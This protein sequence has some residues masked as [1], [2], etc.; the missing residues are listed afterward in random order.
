MKETEASDWA[1]GLVLDSEKE[2]RGEARPMLIFFPLTIP[3]WALGFLT[4]Q[5]EMKRSC[6]PSHR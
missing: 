3:S 4:Y 1:S 6:L 5:M 2:E